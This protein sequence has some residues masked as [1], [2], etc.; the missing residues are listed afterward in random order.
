MVLLKDVQ[1]KNVSML[2]ELMIRSGWDLPK[3]TSRYV[4]HRQLLLVRDHRIF[5][6]KQKNVPYRVCTRPP[7]IAVL[8]LK[9]EDYCRENGI[10][11]GID[12]DRKNFPDKEWLVR[13]VSYVSD[14]S[15]EIFEK[16]YVPAA[17]ND[18]LG[19]G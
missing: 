18:G 19:S 1:I 10:E 17:R 7:T 5:G 4:T 6:V 8:V 13:M 3:R 12:M 11:L 9:L 15:D 16:G 14:G 2:W